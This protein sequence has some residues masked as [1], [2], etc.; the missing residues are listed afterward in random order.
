MCKGD[1]FEGAAVKR[2]FCPKCGQVLA[3]DTAPDPESC[4]ACGIV[5]AKYRAHLA[6]LAQGD[7]PIKT[8][9]R[10]AHEPVS[11]RL[12]DLFC[13]SSDEVILSHFIGK[14]LVFLGLLLWGAYFALSGWRSNVAGMSFLHLINLPFHEFGHVLFRPFGEWLMFLGGSLF[15]CLL[16]VLLGGVFLLREKQ[17][18]SASVCLWWAGQNLVDI[19]PYIGDARAM[20]LSLVGEYSEEVADMREF[21]HDWHNILDRVGLLRWDGGLASL[22]HSL[23]SLLMLAALI[24]MAWYLYQYFQQIRVA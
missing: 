6:A 4:P 5:F 17:V 9:R 13:I 3:R 16:P 7:V 23:G 22:S 2:E 24:G 18:F 12:A 20:A 11:S 21:R 10:V 8:A 19:A 14:S 15:Q 1:E